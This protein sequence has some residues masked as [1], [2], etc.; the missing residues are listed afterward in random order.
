MDAY[1]EWYGENAFPTE[2]ANEGMDPVTARE[3]QLWA[4]MML[5]DIHVSQ[6]AIDEVIKAA[7]YLAFDSEADM[8]AFA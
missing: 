1:D 4:R 7:T 6:R 3:A 8:G 2:S 5:P